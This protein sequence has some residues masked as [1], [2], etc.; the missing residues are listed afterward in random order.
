VITIESAR[1]IGGI[2]RY[3]QT[4]KFPIPDRSGANS[5]IGGVAI[6]ISERVRGEKERQRLAAKLATAQEEERRRIARELHDGLTQ[7]LGGLAIELGRLAAQRPASGRTLAGAFLTLQRRVVRAA[8][9]ARHIAHQLHPSELDDLGL[10]A[11]LRAFCEDFSGREGIGLTFTDHDLPESLPA[12]VAPCLYRVTQ[13]ALR[14]IV[15]HART[16]QAAVTL[17]GNGTGVRLSIQDD[18]VGFNVP[19]PDETIGLGMQSMRER[20]QLLGGT[21]S[22]ISEPGKGAEVLAEVPLPA[23]A[24]AASARQPESKL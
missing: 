13:E 24:A 12:E 22:V 7:D 20:V 9:A 1:Q 17:S 16:R 23:R 2:P 5:F 6:E 10:A 19:P 11:A 8:E 4:V 14:N 21:F 3:F 15:K 18:G